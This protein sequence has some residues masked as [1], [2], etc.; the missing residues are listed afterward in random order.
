MMQQQVPQQQP[1]QGGGFGQAIQ[2]LFGQ[3]MLPFW[4]G[5]A[6]G[7]TKQDQGRLAQGALL[8]GNQLAQQQNQFAQQQALAQQ[9]LAALTQYRNAQL[10]L[11]GR[12]LSIDEQRLKYMMEKPLTAIGELQADLAG[13]RI[14]QNQ[15]DTAI[16]ALTKANTQYN[17][18]IPSG[19]APVMG[20]TGAVSG[21]QAI[22]GGPASALPAETA[23]K[24]AMISTAKEYFNEA[25]QYYKGGEYTGL[26]RA[27]D[28][29]VPFAGRP[30]SGGDSGR[31]RRSIQLSVEAALRLMTGAAVTK[32]ESERY[33]DIFAPGPMDTKETIDQ[34][35]SML[36]N[37]IGKAEEA[38]TR[39]RGGPLG[40]SAVGAPSS[41]PARRRFTATG[42]LE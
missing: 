14:S 19:Y 30:A 4:A 28:V 31:A 17:I 41:A 1:Q 29:G 40:G 5:L 36:K 8:Q 32:E 37:F 38:A 33:T 15:Y 26:D 12:G 3:Q 27:R 10:G 23:G 13:G 6:F 21:L 18:D 9:Q 2:G 7:G 16:G 39:G 20:P 35:L 25:E 34:K 24:A 42:E 11:Q 22:P